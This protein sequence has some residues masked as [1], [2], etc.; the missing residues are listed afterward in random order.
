MKCGWRGKGLVRALE[1]V[2]QR[3]PLEGMGLRLQ[4]RGEVEI[5]IGPSM[6]KL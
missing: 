2:V 6:I 3:S 1:R 5:C 4:G